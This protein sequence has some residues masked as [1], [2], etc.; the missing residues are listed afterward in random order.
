MHRRRPLRLLLTAVVSAL[1]V[2]FMA[3][4]ALAHV[5]VNPGEAAQGSFQEL[6]FRV[7][8]ERDDAGTTKVE[9]AFP[10]DHPIAF[11][12]VKPLPGWTA[13]V[14]KT[15]L[16][17]PLKSDDGEVTEAVSKVTWSGGTIKPGEYQ[18]F[19]V[20]A[21]PLPEGVDKLEF[22]ALQTYSNGEVVRWI[23]STPEGGEEPENPAPT[24]TLT[25]ATGGEGGG[26]DQ[27][28]VAATPSAGGASAKDVDAAGARG[29]V[30][31]V[32]GSIGL[33]LGAAALVIALRKPSASSG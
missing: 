17:T 24:L 11:V 14:D 23:Q 26:G 20:S 22:K 25:A 10:T 12:S 33:L 9:V 30:G 18:D 3:G 6:A 2:V 19:D 32:L 28:T 15:K 29:T 4:P 7:P 5:S 1:S 21:G 16:A 31:I 13:K 8:N 27:P